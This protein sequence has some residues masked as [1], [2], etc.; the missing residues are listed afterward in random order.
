MKKIILFSNTL[1][2]ENL[3]KVSEKLKVNL[4]ADTSFKKRHKEINYLEEKEAKNK[5]KNKSIIYS[6]SEACLPFVLENSS[7]EKLIKTIT[8][9]KDKIKTR[10]LLKELFP[11]YF[12]IKLKASEI[13]NFKPNKKL[14]IKPS[15]GFFSVGVKIIDKETDMNKLKEELVN[16]VKENSNFSKTVLNEEVFIVEDFIEGEEYACDFYF[17]EN[18]EP[19]VV[20]INKH[21]FASEKDVRDVLYYTNKKIITKTLPLVNNF[22]KKLSKLLNPSIIPI[23]MEFKINKGMVYPIEFNPLRFGG[24]LL[25]D[26]PYYAFGSN[27]YEKFFKQEKVNWSKAIEKMRDNNYAFVIGRREKKG[28]VKHD[29]FKKTFSNLM[30]YVKISNEKEPAFAIV[31]SKD[32]NIENLKKYLYDDFKKYVI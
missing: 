11:N 7:D 26:L 28:E 22:L 20:S 2:S 23:H 10:E 19:V 17:N 1:T 12:F 31:F 13:N 14:I 15:I 25:A 18:Q 9:L 5:L 6:N 3:L 8:T 24:Y 29:K 32:E 21:L 27:S 16:E 4:F 30:K